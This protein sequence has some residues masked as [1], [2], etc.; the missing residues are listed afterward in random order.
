MDNGNSNNSEVSRSFV[1]SHDKSS[2]VEL[3]K[4]RLLCERIIKR[5]KLKRELVLCS[6]EILASNRE[7]VALS[8]LTC[9][10]LC[11]TDVSSESATT[12]LKGYT[13]D[14]KS[15][16]EAIQRS[17]DITVDS[18]IAGKRRIKFPVSMDNDQKT[19]DSSTSQQYHTRVR[20]LI[21]KLSEE[22][23][24]AL[25]QGNKLRQEL[26]AQILPS[27]KVQLRS[28]SEAGALKTSLLDN[29]NSLKA[30]VY[31]RL[32]HMEEAETLV[33]Q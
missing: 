20:A 22:K 18:T 31:Q 33:K 17:D 5:E 13:D 15:G 7:V 11:P 28:S 25:Q 1:D 26:L 27:Q 32:M 8:A 9:S 2:E 4:L 12:S 16:N 14:Y 21:S 6:H 3:E 30:V 24:A 19:D 29:M 23:S 10:S